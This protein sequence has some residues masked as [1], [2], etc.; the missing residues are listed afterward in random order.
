[1]IQGKILSKTDKNIVQNNFSK[2]K[3]RQTNTAF[4]SKLYAIQRIFDADFSCMKILVLH[5]CGSCGN[6]DNVFCLRASFLF[7]LHNTIIFPKQ[8]DKKSIS[9]FNHRDFFCKSKKAILFPKYLKEII[10]SEN[11]VWTFDFCCQKH[12]RISS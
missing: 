3:F 8:N 9:I 11:F 4:T 2:E 10:F 5:K 12:E 6:F 7:I 1:M